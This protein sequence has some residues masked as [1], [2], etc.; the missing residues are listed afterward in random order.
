VPLEQVGPGRYR[1]LFEAGTEGAYLVGVAEKKD[2]KLVGSEVGSLVIP[3][4]PELRALSVDESLLHD[5]AAL[6]GGAAPTRP[7][8]VFAQNRRPARVWVEAWPQLLG[9]ALLL[10]LLDVALRRIWGRG[11]FRRDRSAG[12][13]AAST[14]GEGRMTDSIVAARFGGFGRRP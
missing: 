5:V 11:P 6:S 1:G 4:S 7:G 10:F 2:Q 13:T 12:R 14:T 9:L 3:Y 8:D